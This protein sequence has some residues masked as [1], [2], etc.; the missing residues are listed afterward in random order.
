MICE[1]N[2]PQ[3]EKEATIVLRLMTNSGSLQ[4]SMR[5]GNRSPAKVGVCEDCAYQ[6][7]HKSEFEYQADGLDIK[8]FAVRV[9]EGVY[10][11]ISFKDQAEF[12]KKKRDE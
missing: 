3:C 2:D 5:L 12:D 7:V 1:F 8:E 9:S 10:G 4:C 11:F 6:L